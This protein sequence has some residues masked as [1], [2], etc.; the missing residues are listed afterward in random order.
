MSKRHF[1]KKNP[2]EIQKIEFWEMSKRLFWKKIRTKYYRSGSLDQDD[3]KIFNDFE[4]RC[5]SEGNC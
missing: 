1:W 3:N 2:T 4:R 5:R